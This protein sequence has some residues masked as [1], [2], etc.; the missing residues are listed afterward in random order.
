MWNNVKVSIKNKYP[1]IENEPEKFIEQS[2]VEY[3]SLNKLASIDEVIDSLYQENV[4][5]KNTKLEFNKYKSEVD[6]LKKIAFS[7]ALRHGL[8]TIG[9]AAL[10]TGAA[11]VVA[12]GASAI[13]DGI[14][15]LYNKMTRKSKLEKIFKYNP[16][17]R[18]VDQDR[19]NQT[20]SDIEDFNP[21]ISKSP[22]VMGTLLSDA[23][24][25]DGIHLDKIKGV[26][27]LR[28][29]SDAAKPLEMDVFKTKDK[30][31]PFKKM[32]KKIV[33]EQYG[34]LKTKPERDIFKEN[35]NKQ[36][37]TAS[38]TPASKFFN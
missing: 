15:N 1:G 34:E 22:I 29:D 35:Y 20:I 25:E 10:A 33:A 27:D 26:S 6:V 12:G 24:T 18:N 14:S 19:L 38:I 9:N 23:M 17:L 3:A 8:G 13:K 11:M 16:H 30:K 36:K 7:P 31:D 32:E 28:R 37:K 5:S 4:V 2:L 21:G